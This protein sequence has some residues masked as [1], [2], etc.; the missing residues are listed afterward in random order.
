MYNGTVH[1]NMYIRICMH[2]YK[3]EYM[4]ISKFKYLNSYLTVYV[5]I[6]RRKSILNMKVVKRIVFNN[7]YWTKDELWIY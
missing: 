1:K 3:Y 4:L 6:K 5:K 7:R 2:I